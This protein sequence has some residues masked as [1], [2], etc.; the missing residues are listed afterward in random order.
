MALSAWGR[1]ERDWCTHR[2]C[3]QEGKLSDSPH[4]RGNQWDLRLGVLAQLPT[5]LVFSEVLIP[6]RVLQVPCAGR[7]G[8]QFAKQDSLLHHASQSMGEVLGEDF[9]DRS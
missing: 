4:P 6:L 8:R 1:G 2:T 3:I 5:G 9:A 7:K